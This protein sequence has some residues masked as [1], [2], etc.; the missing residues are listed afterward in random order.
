[1]VLQINHINVEALLAFNRAGGLC[2]RGGLDKFVGV[3]KED[4]HC[5]L[6]EGAEKECR[7]HN[8]N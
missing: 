8:N 5:L 7:D 6:H 4:R 2:L 1:M 3:A